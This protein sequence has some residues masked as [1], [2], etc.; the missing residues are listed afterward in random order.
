MDDS[1]GLKDKPIEIDA[2]IKLSLAILLAITSCFCHSGAD[3]IG[4]ALY[5]LAITILLQG[6][7]GFVLKNLLSYGV[8]ILFPYCFGI[9]LS[10]LISRLY[11]P[12]FFEVNLPGAFLK[13]L[14]LF[15]VWYIGNLYFFTTS[16]ESIVNVLNKAFSPLNAIGIPAAKYLNMVLFIVNELTRSVSQFKQNILEQARNIF[17]S[18]RRGFKPKAIDLSNILVAFIANSLERTDEI[19]EQIELNRADTGQYTLRISK[20]EILAIL[21]SIIFMVF[22]CV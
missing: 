13:M 4:F 22:F 11:S 2:G 6:G 5:L 20:N 18:G 16:L 3:L 12:Y 9:L 8:I 14:K 7:P 15:F 17:K 21:S 19:Q 10:L 1:T